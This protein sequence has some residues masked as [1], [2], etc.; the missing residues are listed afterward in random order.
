MSS[1][2]PDHKIK[3]SVSGLTGIATSKVEFLDGGVRACKPMINVIC[4][5]ILF[6]VAA[7]ADDRFG[8][9][10]AFDRRGYDPN[11]IMPLVVELGASWIRDGANVDKFFLSTD[12]TGATGQYQFPADDLAW[13][14]AVGTYG[15]KVVFM[16]DN[17]NDPV[18]F[19]KVAAFVAQYALNNKL[20]I[21]AIEVLNYPDRELF[22]STQNR[23]FAMP[24]PLWEQQYAAIAK[25]AYI[26]VKAV[27][28]A[29]L[30]IGAGA[31]MPSTWC[32]V[33]FGMSLDG[34]T[35]H[36]YFTS[37]QPEFV[38]NNSSTFGRDGIATADAAGDYSSS[39]LM[40]K[41]WAAKNGVSTQM[42][43]TE[44]GVTNG[45]W[46][47][48][49]NTAGENTEA[50]CG[51]WAIRRLT[52]ALGLAVDHTFLYTVLNETYDPDAGF[53]NYGL[54]TT[55]GNKKQAFYFVQRVMGLL[56]GELHSQHSASA[57]PT[58]SRIYAFD[59]AN[60]NSVIGYWNGG[61][62]TDNGPLTKT[63]I[64]YNHPN[65]KFIHRFDPV[66]NT[67][68][69]VHWVQSGENVIVDGTP[70]ST[71]PQYITIQ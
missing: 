30:V 16:L 47:V 9:A 14:N 49:K 60:G 19:S 6:A 68:N 66:S 51:I 27:N 36:P 26:A 1:L 44:W 31:N 62:A 3:E 8:I 43:E 52:E 35:N 29:M 38:P 25:A 45:F 56:S 34:Y 32:E 33:Q 61:W 18:V 12:P 41:A 24:E 22:T 69:F 50:E 2:K 10:T 42:W 20:P 63:T 17:N 15:V 39:I 65:A 13:L 40:F 70:V 5:L 48:G 59:A 53:N 64:T 58:V 54:V 55:G 28:P 4:A 46:T 23:Y 7:Q 21:A 67:Y 57:S 37:Q 71:T 11:Y